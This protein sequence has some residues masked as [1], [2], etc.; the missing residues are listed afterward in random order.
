VVAAS[1]SNRLPQLTIAERFSA[2]ARKRSSGHAS[3]TSG[4][5]SASDIRTTK[6]AIALILSAL[7]PGTDSQ[8]GGADGPNVT[9]SGSLSAQAQRSGK[10]SRRSSVRFGSY[11]SRRW[12]KKRLFG[13][14][15]LKGEWALCRSGYPP[16]TV[17]HLRLS[18][19]NCLAHAYA[20]GAGP[21]ASTCALL[22][23]SPRRCL[24]RG[25]QDGANHRF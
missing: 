19:V 25:G 4:L 11:A 6:S 1:S 24:I 23:P 8:G 16:A 5:L 17:T 18:S 3:G 12:A 9:R 21:A 20:G 13:P 15:A 2:L 10:G 7:P 14:A 22:H